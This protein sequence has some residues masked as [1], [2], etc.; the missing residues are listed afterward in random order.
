ME[1][2][3]GNFIDID[4]RNNLHDLQPENIK[5]PTNL[6]FL[7]ESLVKHGFALPFAVW[8]DQGKYYCV[9]GHTR[10][11]VLSELASEGVNVPTYLKAFE[12]LAKDRKEAVEILLE[13]YN[14]KH[15]PFVKDTLTE[16]VKVE[17]VQVNIESLH[18]E[19]ISE[20]DPNDI[21]IKQEKK[22]WVPDCLFPSNNPYDIPTL[23]PHTQPIYVDVPLRPYG[24]EKRSKQGVGTYHFYV[25]DYRFEAIWDNPSA[26]IESGC[27]NIVEPNCS[28]YETT[29]I[30]Y[31]IFQIYKK[32][33][34][35]R[36][37]QDYNINIF[38]DLN[39]TEKFASYNRMGIPEGYNAFFTRGYESRLNNLEKELVIAQ[40]ISG[41]DNPNLVVYGGGK[42]AKEFCY[43]KNLTCIS[44]TTLDI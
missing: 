24:S 27:K 11:Q 26:I 20:Q 28:L 30:S 4:W 36:F 19:T 42:K 31:G 33:W 37:L 21:N 9:D 15:N 29:P 43:K 13:V 23:L 38:I 16:W 39:V 41:L 14:Q 3:I 1:S 7:K 6:K 40:E 17:D 5:T 32:R 22:V 25:D 18:V 34:I 35:A 44:E 10:K 8:N 2:R 12:I